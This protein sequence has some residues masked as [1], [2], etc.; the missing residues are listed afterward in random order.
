MAR[1]SIDDFVNPLFDKQRAVQ[2]EVPSRYDSRRREKVI[3]G[4][5]VTDNFNMIGYTYF[6]SEGILYLNCVDE[7]RR[8]NIRLLEKRIDACSD[9]EKY[10]KQADKKISRENIRTAMM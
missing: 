10:L 9:F 2:R 7:E 3:E 1:L 6:L 4:V 8:C 5:T